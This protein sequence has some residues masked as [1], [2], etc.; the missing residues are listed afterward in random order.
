[1]KKWIGLTALGVALGFGCYHLGYRRGYSQAQ[2]VEFTNAEADFQVDGWPRDNWHSTSY[3]RGY[4]QGRHYGSA[5][6][7]A[8]DCDECGQLLANLGVAAGN[9]KAAKAVGKLLVEGRVSPTQLQRAA[10]TGGQP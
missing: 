5:E 3:F 9:D 7:R 1:M 4:N 10:A 8:K 2:R 6:T